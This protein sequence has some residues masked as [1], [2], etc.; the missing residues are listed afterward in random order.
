MGNHGQSTSR[1]GDS[2]LEFRSKVSLS[3]WRW[4]RTLLHTPEIWEHHEQANVN[5]NC[6]IYLRFQ[7][8]FPW[9]FESDKAFSD[10]IHCVEVNATFLVLVSVIARPSWLNFFFFFDISFYNGTNT[11]VMLMSCALFLAW[12]MTPDIIIKIWMFSLSVSTTFKRFKT[13]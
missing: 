4:L 9:C 6:N 3:R 8:Y 13:V 5:L 2:C 11:E 12:N 7:K 1:F 10:H